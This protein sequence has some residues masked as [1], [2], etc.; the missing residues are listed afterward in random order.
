MVEGLLIV[1]LEGRVAVYNTSAESLLDLPPES[2]HI[3]EPLPET[4]A[5]AIILDL[6]A[7]AD[8]AREPGFVERAVDLTGGRTISIQA[9]RLPAASGSNP[10]VFL[11]IR[12]AHEAERVET[13][14]R[15]FVANV[16]HELRT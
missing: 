4:P 13:L 8:I 2:L 14:R 9:T 16:S 5:R 3:G 11:T 7:Q 6:I 12:D 10:S 1:D 15:D